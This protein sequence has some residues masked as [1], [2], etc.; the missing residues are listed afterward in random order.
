VDNRIKEIIAEAIM[1][2]A[3]LCAEE[4]PE[5]YLARWLKIEKGL[6]ARLAKWLVEHRD[7]LEGL[8]R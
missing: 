8:L 1:R 7:G 4:P 5:E 2:P 6:A 3:E